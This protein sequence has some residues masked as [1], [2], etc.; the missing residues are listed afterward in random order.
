M[1]EAHFTHVNLA[2]ADLRRAR[3]RRISLHDVNFIL[4]QLDDADLSEAMIWTVAFGDTDLSTVKGLQN[5][6]PF[7]LFLDVGTL[8]RSQGKIPEHLLSGANV[9]ASLIPL[10]PSLSKNS[11]PQ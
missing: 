2:H 10:L 1:S 3:M 4:T 7:E 11:A 8:L 9:P 6:Q 5:I